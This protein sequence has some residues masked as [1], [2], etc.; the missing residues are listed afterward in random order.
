VVYHPLGH[1][2]APEHIEHHPFNL[3]DLNKGH[4][5]PS[6]YLQHIIEQYDQL[7]EITVF[8]STDFPWVSYSPE[9]FQEDV[10]G[11]S[12]ETI[13]FSAENDGFMFLLAACD[14]VWDEV[15]GDLH[16]RFNDIYQAK[17]RPMFRK[18]LSGLLQ[19]EEDDDVWRHFRFAPTG[20]FAVTRAAI[21]RKPLEYYDRIR[22]VT[23]LGVGET[24]PP[25]MESF[26]ERFWPA[27]FQS[28]C[29]SGEQ[30][31]C[32]HMTSIVCSC[33][34]LR[35]WDTNHEHCW[36]RPFAVP[37]SLRPD[38]QVH[39]DS[40]LVTVTFNY[41]VPLAS[42][43]L[44]F[45]IYKDLYPKILYIGPISSQLVVRTAREVHNIPVAITR[46][47]LLSMPGVLVYETWAKVTEAYPG[48]V[49]Y[50]FMHDDM[51]IQASVLRTLN[52]S[53]VWTTDDVICAHV[54]DWDIRNGTKHPW[55]WMDLDVGL[56]A[57]DAM[58]KHENFRKVLE[59]CT[60]GDVHHWC[61]GQSDFLYIPAAAVWS[62][63]NVMA[64]M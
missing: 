30:Y 10:Q 16:D 23:T 20:C 17:P 26:L 61:T 62:F 2:G 35:P 51:A 13:I 9:N 12:N 52:R 38:P 42:L 45:K 37:P 4:S 29:T 48:H 34:N 21:H 63:Q 11:L 64:M 40:P 15:D 54:D 55:Y 49:G 31:H 25:P 41:D 58:L 19:H 32:S 50:I 3:R 46:Q 8:S 47:P 7:A 57:M 44:H 5:Q 36:M 1:S 27:V 24:A 59:T 6:G 28:K 53:Q 43:L 39:P 56:D 60:G 18:L 22:E 33:P 14:N